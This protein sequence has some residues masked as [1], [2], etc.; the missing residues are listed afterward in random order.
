LPPPGYRRRQ[1]W[2]RRRAVH[3][4]PTPLIEEA[5][6]CFIPRHHTCAF[7]PHTAAA[8]PFCLTDIYDVQ[9]E[10]VVLGQCAIAQRRLQGTRRSSASAACCSNPLLSAGIAR[11][12]VVLLLR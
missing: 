5:S 11:Y 6:V 9:V 3:L 4:A 2:Q 12:E 8:W 7:A 10:G 1:K